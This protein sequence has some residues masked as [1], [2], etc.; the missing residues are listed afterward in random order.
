M[1]PCNQTFCTVNC[2]KTPTSTTMTS[3][4]TWQIPTMTLWQ[5]VEPGTW[6]LSMA[7]RKATTE[8]TFTRTM[9]NGIPLITISNLEQRLRLMGSIITKPR[10]RC[11]IGNKCVPSRW[12]SQSQNLTAQA[13]WRS[14]KSRERCM[15]FSLMLRFKYCLQ[16]RSV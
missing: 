16:V 6:K 14:H 8:H 3:S 9:L 15:G 10:N 12:G 7:S 1:C 5:I 2:A 4:Y 13:L 11:T